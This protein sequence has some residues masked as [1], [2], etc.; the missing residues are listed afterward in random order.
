MNRIALILTN[1][2]MPERTDAIAEHL[3][4]TVNYPIDYYIVDNGSDLVKPSKYTTVRLEKN[5]QVTGGFLAGVDA[6]V[7]SGNEYLAYWFMIT[8]A[9]FIDIDWIDPL[10]YLIPTMKKPDT[11]AVSPSVNFPKHCAWEPWMAPR[12]KGV[13]RI[14][15]MDYI[16]ALISAEKYHALG[17][18]RPELI[19]MWGVPGEMNWKARKNGWKLYI[20]D[21][22][23][24]EKY[25][26]IGYEMDRMNMSAEDRRF[27]ASK[28]SDDIL[29]PIYGEEYRE[30]F[31]YEFTENLRGD[32]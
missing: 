22:Y 9:K 1:Y 13:R 31:R 7:K 20:N 3:R 29:N 32:Y 5:K 14:W 4:F 11:F 18:F 6:A 12:D 21:D 23:T 15:G 10:D 24:I 19:Y 2:N 17:G 30:K 25:T 28:N 26:D 27:L 16:C 8:S